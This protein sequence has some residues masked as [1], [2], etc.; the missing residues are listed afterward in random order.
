MKNSVALTWQAQI[1]CGLRRG[2]E[3]CSPCQSIEKVYKICRK[4]V[5]QRGG[6][7]VTVTPTKFFYLGGEEDGAI[8]GIIQYPRFPISH[9]L[10]KERTI[11]LAEILRVE[12]GQFR[13]SVVFPDETIMLE[14]VKNA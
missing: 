5:Q 9:K 14:E 3:V 8:V 1:F 6:W 10:L 12:L 7:C 4:C 2:Y 13:V 11:E